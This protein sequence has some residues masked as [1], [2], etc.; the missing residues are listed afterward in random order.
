MEPDHH[1]AGR[2]PYKRGCIH[3][4][5]INIEVIAPAGLGIIDVRGIIEH[6]PVRS[7]GYKF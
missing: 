5:H 3:D 6:F 1:E 7:P 4:C 2:D